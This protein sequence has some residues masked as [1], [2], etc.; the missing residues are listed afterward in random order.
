[1]ANKW[2]VADF[3]TTSA[4]YY[5]KNGFTKVWLYGLCDDECNIIKIGTSI[6]DFMQ[7]AKRLYGKV[8][9]FHNLKFDGTFILD[10]LLNNGYEYKDDL[11][12]VDKGFNALIG[13]MG[14]FY[15]ITF[16]FTKNKQV[17]FY[18]SLKVLPF[19]VEK[20]A[21]DFNMAIEKEKIN[22]DDYTLNAKS[23]IYQIH[24]IKI[25]ATA[26]KAI[27]E[28]GMTKMTT[29]SCAYTSFRSMYNSECFDT[30]FPVLPKDFLIE[31]RQAYRGGRCQVNPI[32]QGKVLKGV[33][34]F[35]IN[36]MYPWAMHDM[37]LPYGMPIEL[38]KPNQYP[39]ELY[40]VEIGFD[41]K[42]DCLP[43]LLK[44]NTL[45][46]DDTY[47]IDSDG[48][49][50][51][52]ISNIDLDLVKRNYNVYYL[53]YVKMYG[54]TC[55][56][57][58][59][60]AYIDKW[61]ARKKVDKGAQKLV[62]KLMLNSLYGKF[63]SNP[64]GQHKIPKL[65]DDKIL[66]FDNSEVEEMKP[67]Y[68]PIAIAVTSW[69]HKK[70]DDGIHMTGIENFVYVD[71]DSIHTLGTLPDDE[72]DQTILGKYKLEG[73]ETISK[74]VRQKCYVYLQDDKYTI[75]CAGMTQDMKDN[76]IKQYGKNIF[77]EFK[78]GF[79]CN[80]KLIPKRVKGGTIL[81]ETT[82]TIN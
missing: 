65:D 52:Y 40:K 23:L 45:Y 25:V 51:L 81:Y 5:N 55:T 59:F 10:W 26:L 8:I 13:D 27:K 64:E 35:D 74:Y 37:P 15:S 18:D 56:T 75:T 22:Y 61:Y 63:G 80:G 14:Q 31:W 32:Y 49:I 20:L 77:K 57:Y 24:D 69:A 67:Y 34:R 42:P 50:E 71:T 72:I 33:K 58:S 41:L 36:S 16:K 76:V 3:E 62:D 6:D 38:D 47:Y 29:A 79:T 66:S 30:R 68:L 17:H 82:F 28:E 73:I 7:Q 4:I 2:Y 12:K 48:V 9:Y 1:M 21:K 70:I 19:K 11:S 54:F 39:F 46:Q 44:K 43:S 78:S 53:K 60:R